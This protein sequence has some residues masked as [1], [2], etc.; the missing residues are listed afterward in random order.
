[1]NDAFVIF[2]SG[3][4]HAG[5]STIA[6]ALA[7]VIPDTEFIDGDF[8]VRAEDM[9]LSTPLPLQWEM[10]LEKIIEVT[11]SKLAAGRNVSIAWPL[12]QKGYERV[13]RSLPHD[14]RLHCVFLNPAPDRLVH[15]RATRPLSEWSKQRGL[16]MHAEGYPSHAFWDLVL[17]TN[18]QLPYNTVQAILSK[19]K[20]K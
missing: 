13:E 19:L 3:V 4:P 17:D 7:G 16:E 5:K 11:H 2:I 9:P 12:S 14:V 15:D 18:G 6:A 1:M 10:K 20:L 8:V